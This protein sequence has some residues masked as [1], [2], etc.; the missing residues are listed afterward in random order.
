[1]LRTLAFISTLLS[2]FV[3]SWFLTRLN[4]PQNCINSS[5]VKNIVVH[6][7]LGTTAIRS[8]DL[9]T[10]VLSSR[11][12]DVIRES[13]IFRR[14]EAIEMLAPYLDFA[15][16]PITIKVLVKTKNALEIQGATLNVSVDVLQ[17]EGLLEK[18]IL[19][20]KLNNYNPMSAAVLSDFLWKEL[21]VND[22]HVRKEK[23]WPLYFK[24]LRDYCQSAEILPMHF[25]FCGAHNLLADSF[26]IKTESDAS[27]A[28]WAMKTVYVDIL[29]E[30]YRSL[31]ILD[32]QKMLERL[33]FLGEISDEFI[34]DQGFSADLFKLDESYSQMLTSWLMPL[35]LTDGRVE[36]VLET[37][38]FKSQK[39]LN[40]LVI[41]RSSRNVFPFDY[42]FPSGDDIREPLI[43]QLGIKKYFYP[44]H[45]AMNI[46]RKEIFARKMI[47]TMI[48]V[49]CD[50][51]DVES[52]LEYSGLAK[53][54]IFMRQCNSEDINW[55]LV[56]RQG[57]SRYL[58]NNIDVQFIEFNLSALLLAKRVRGPMHNSEDFSL[59]FSSWKK[60]L[61]W[62][63]VVSDDAIAKVQRP[64]ASIDGVGRFRIF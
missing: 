63:G 62:Q 56:A 37:Y 18:T 1:M 19:F 20:M 44:N 26:I 8:C 39:N 34:E 10:R 5:L 31:D 33:I 41:D 30:L 52:L 14:L 6:E 4:G 59:S 22:V 38:L 47:K 55:D 36:N 11:A 61:M 24:S 54:V 15:D 28:P 48:Y 49:S 16:V 13:R 64:M 32:K 42:N 2:I 3:V 57:L 60:W 53:S 9:Y 7:E 50:M 21:I 51:P 58:K 43:V 35:M 45:L 25:S 27:A 29:R 46:D 12:P 40:Y 17:R 23:T